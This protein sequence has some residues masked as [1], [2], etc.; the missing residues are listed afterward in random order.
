MKTIILDL[1]GCKTLDELHERIRIAFDFPDY[2]GANWSAFWDL[3]WSECSAS[4]IVVIGEQ[5]MPE[6]LKRHI[7]KLNE[8]LQR[9]VDFRS[10]NKLDS[11][12]FELQN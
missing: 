4:H 8:I 2:Y 12:S 11:L 10:K 6:E 9:T 7:Q 1:T 5:V 3:M